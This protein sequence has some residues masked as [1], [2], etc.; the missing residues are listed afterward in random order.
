MSINRYDRVDFYSY[1]FQ[2]KEHKKVCSVFVADGKLSFEGERADKVEKMMK[3]N[4]YLKPFWEIG[5]YAV[6]ERLQYA[7][8]GTLFHATDVVGASAL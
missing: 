7:F 4:D 2:D 3:D 6:L 5:P 8:Q 1:D